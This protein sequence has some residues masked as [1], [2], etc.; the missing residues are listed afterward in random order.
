MFKGVSKMNIQ[1]ITLA[2]LA[3]TLVMWDL[4]SHHVIT[5]N[6]VVLLDGLTQDKAKAEVWALY[7]AFKDL[8]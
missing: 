8:A 3:G 7:A 6:E 2:T 5:L 1:R 4:G